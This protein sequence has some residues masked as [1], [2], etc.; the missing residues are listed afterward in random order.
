M[1]CPELETGGREVSQH[2][3]VLELYL[4][5][6]ELDF[7]ICG[8][9]VFRHLFVAGILCGQCTCVCEEKGF[10]SIL[11]SCYLWDGEELFVVFLP[12]V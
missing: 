5:A 9:D 1:K 4:G 3:C 12:L 8:G 7:R 6:Q 11:Y 10:C 2:V